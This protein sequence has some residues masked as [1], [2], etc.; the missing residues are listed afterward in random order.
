[1]LDDE[2]K[3]RIRAE[4]IYREEVRKDLSYPK[5]VRK[6]IWSLLNSPFG[7]WFLSSVVLAGLL[8][9]INSLQQSEKERSEVRQTINSL[10]LELQ[11]RFSVSAT[12]IE[13]G[14]SNN[15]YSVAIGRLNQATEIFPKFRNRSFAS[16][17]QELALV[18]VKSKKAPVEAAR[19]SAMDLAAIANEIN[20]HT[21]AGKSIESEKL[22][23][24]KA[25]YEIL[26][27]ENW[28][29]IGP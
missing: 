29:P 3:N 1:M 6:Q 24:I 26:R 28:L 7:L 21:I 9:A 13:K 2:T 25:F 20:N 15:S 12:A 10:A 4:E 22:A 19:K 18:V 8:F 16:L 27:P 14:S 23:K 11:E 5:S 17:L